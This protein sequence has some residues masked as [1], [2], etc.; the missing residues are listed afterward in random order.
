[1]VDAAQSVPHFPVDVQDLDC[2]FFA[3][4]G[5][6]M[7]APTGS[8]TRCIRQGHAHRPDRNDKKKPWTKP[9]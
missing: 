7:F 9:Y 6:K 5:H 2:D 8:G 3:F 1:M 4:S